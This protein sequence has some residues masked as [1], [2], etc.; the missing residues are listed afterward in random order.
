MSLF[1]L[2]T[3]L[4]G[5]VLWVIGFAIGHR[6][7]LESGIETGW[8]EGYDFATSDSEIR[9]QLTARGAE[10][11]PTTEREPLVTLALHST[12]ATTEP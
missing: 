5:T 7:G 8:A 1:I 11:V 9:W 12:P 6:M 10:S 2:T 4:I 3:I